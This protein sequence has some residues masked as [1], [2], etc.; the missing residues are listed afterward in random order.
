[1]GNEG[2]S[3]SS[4]EPS[5]AYPQPSGRDDYGNPTCTSYTPHYAYQNPTGRDNYGNPTYDWY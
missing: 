1:M 3:G 2:W 5:Y 4:Y